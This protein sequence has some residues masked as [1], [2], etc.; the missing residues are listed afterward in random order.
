M[1]FIIDIG[2]DFIFLVV[3]EFNGVGDE[4]CDCGWIFFL[5]FFGKVVVGECVLVI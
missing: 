5:G 4:V 2:F 1:L 3:E